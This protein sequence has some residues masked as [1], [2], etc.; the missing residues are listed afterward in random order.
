VVQG[1]C[2]DVARMSCPTLY[3]YFSVFAYAPIEMD[4]FLAHASAS[5]PSTGGG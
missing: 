1:L 4:T 2:G 5:R 3:D